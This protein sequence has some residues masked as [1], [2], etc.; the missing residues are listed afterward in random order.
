MRSHLNSEPKLQL[1]SNDTQISGEPAISAYLERILLES[2]RFKKGQNQVLLSLGITAFIALNCV[3]FSR[4][5]WFYAALGAYAAG[6]M[7]PSCYSCFEKGAGSLALLPVGAA[8]AFSVLLFAWNRFCRSSSFFDIVLYT[9]TLCAFSTHFY[10]VVLS[11]KLC[12]PCSVIV[13]C[14]AGLLTVAGVRTFEFKKI[15]WKPNFQ[16]I[17]LSLTILAISVNLAKA[18]EGTRFA[19][20]IIPNSML[21]LRLHQV[22]FRNV[23]PGPHSILMIASPLCNACSLAEAAFRRKRI[24]YL[25]VQPC[26]ILQSEGCFYSDGPLRTPTIIQ[27][28]DGVISKVEI[29][30]PEDY[31]HEN[32]LLDAFASSQ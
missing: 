19:S 32:E 17:A 12:T 9:F 14:C 4:W 25:K 6:I 23:D 28:K 11:P 13:F 7:Y 10:L 30:W 1:G 8:A 3:F 20:P 24:P 18:F 2:D 21:G 27:T 29:G 15:H 16:I 31:E 26:T 5:Q 22:G